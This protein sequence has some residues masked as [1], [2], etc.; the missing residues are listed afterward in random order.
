MQLVKINKVEGLSLKNP[1][2][3]FGQQPVEIR[4]LDMCRLGIPVICCGSDQLIF[5]MKNN[6]SGFATHHPSNI[7]S[8]QLSDLI[9]N[10]SFYSLNARKVFIDNYD[11]NRH[12]TTALYPVLDSNL[13]QV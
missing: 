2:N 3:K 13:N 10:Y 8:E 9:A 11:L 7:K 12:M 5:F 6:K 4:H 1:E